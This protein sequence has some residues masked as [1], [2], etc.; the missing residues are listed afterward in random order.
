MS[1]VQGTQPLVQDQ[2]LVSV[3]FPTPF[4]ETPETILALV[5]NLSADPT[6][7]AIHPT[8]VSRAP[9]GFTASLSQVPNSGNYSLIW[10]VSDPDTIAQLVNQALGGRRITQLTSLVSLQPTDVMPVVRTWPVPHTR[11][12]GWGQMLAEFGAASGQAVVGFGSGPSTP[13]DPGTPGS[14]IW[15]PPYLYLKTDGDWVRFAGGTWS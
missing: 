1:L 10:Y 8:I 6:I 7:L 9:T 11:K 3:V 15:D 5:E 4:A 12:V 14:W 13:S 2:D